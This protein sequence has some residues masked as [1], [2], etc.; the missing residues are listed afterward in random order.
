MIRRRFLFWVGFGLFSVGE[1][2]R[3]RAF[4]DVAA[5]LMRSSEGAAS[6]AATVTPEHWTAAGNNAWRWYVRENLVDG[7]WRVTGITTPIHRRT[8]ERYKEKTGY[9]D[10]SLV[11]VEMRIDP[12]APS[13][14][15]SDGSVEVP[16]LPDEV[17]KVRHGRP[18]SRWLRSLHADELKIWLKT[19]EPNE[20][21]VSGMTFFEHLTRDHFFRAENV[22]TLTLDEQAKL[23]GA[24]HDGY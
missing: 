1:R 22:A 18:P 4:D 24:A 8:G 13:V 11:P 17:R 10:E 5:A 6:V 19:V 3:V 23:H 21:G 9:L 7:Q 2:V 20:A 14:A 15:E 16:G 12:D